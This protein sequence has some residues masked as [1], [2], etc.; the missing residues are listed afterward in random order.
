MV[1]VEYLEQ[2]PIVLGQVHS[3]SN[4]EQPCELLLRESTRPMRVVIEIDVNQGVLWGFCGDSVVLKSSCQACQ[5]LKKN[6]RLRCEVV[7]GELSGHMQL[8]SIETDLTLSPRGRVDSVEDVTEA[9]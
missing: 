9:W 4:L 2:E 8:C 3:V 6:M 5:N 1:E 7:T